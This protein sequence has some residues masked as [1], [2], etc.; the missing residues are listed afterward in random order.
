[1]RQTVVFSHFRAYLKN[2]IIVYK[3]EGDL[4]RVKNRNVLCY[5]ILL[6]FGQNTV[7]HCCFAQN[8]TEVN[9]IDY[10]G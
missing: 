1:M 10:S 3:N 7:I 9:D 2:I 5:K 4:L 6:S 8:N